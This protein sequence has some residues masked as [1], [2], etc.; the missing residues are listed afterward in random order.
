V[1]RCRLDYADRYRNLRWHAVLAPHI[2]EQRV[3]A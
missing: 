3:P 1:C 2:H